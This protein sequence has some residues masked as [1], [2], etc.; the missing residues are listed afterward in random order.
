M[1]AIVFL[2][3]SL[4][5]FM[6]VFCLSFRCV[7]RMCGVRVGGDCLWLTAVVRHCL[8]LC[9]V[10]CAVVVVCYDGFL[11]VVVVSSCL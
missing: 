3:G 8:R 4:K 10:G 6:F 7:P 1:F 5:R 2:C 11:W 9:V